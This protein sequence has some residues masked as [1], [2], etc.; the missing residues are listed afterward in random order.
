MPIPKNW[1][2]E[3]AI[4]W[5]TLQGYLVESNVRLQAVKGG[6][7]TEA[8]VIGARVR[9]EALEIVHLETGALAGGLEA[10]LKRVRDKF[11]EAKRK[12]VSDIVSEKVAWESEQTYEAIYI[13]SSASRVEE[14][15]RELEKDNIKLLRLDEF[16]REEVL[17]TIEGWKENQR[18]VGRRK[19]VEGKRKL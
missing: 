16:V 7:I 11:Q 10:N 4:E 13:A 3:L 8:D 12:V 14:L 18:K 15:K 9:N 6:G 1:V 5:L 17:K 19:S 2:E